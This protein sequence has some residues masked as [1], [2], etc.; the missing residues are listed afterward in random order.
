M[1]FFKVCKSLASF[2]V[3]LYIHRPFFELVNLGTLRVMSPLVAAAAGTDR[4]GEEIESGWSAG[5]TMALSAMLPQCARPTSPG[6]SEETRTPRAAKAK[7]GGLSGFPRSATDRPADCAGQRRRA[8]V[9]AAGRRRGVGGW[10]LRGRLRVGGT[11]RSTSGPRRS[12]G[13]MP[14]A[15]LAAE[16]AGALTLGRRAAV[17]ASPR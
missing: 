14:R 2:V 6:V 12:T 9:G 13:R 1:P 7:G 3:N 4:A 8:S 16:I 10:S 17:F 15:G 5:H 11:A